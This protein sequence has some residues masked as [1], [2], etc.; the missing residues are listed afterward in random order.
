[1]YGCSPSH[2]VSFLSLLC[3]VR[4]ENELP[5]LALVDV[6]GGRPADSHEGGGA[7]APRKL[8]PL[9]HV[10][11]SLHSNRPGLQLLQASWHPHSGSHFAVLA[12]DGRLRLYS[13]AGVAEAEQ[14]FHLKLQ[15]SAGGGSGGG[16]AGEGSVRRLGSLG[17][18]GRAAASAAPLRRATAFVW[19]PPVG[20]GCFT[21][22]VLASD[23]GIYSLCPVAPFGVRVSARALGLLVGSSP[24]GTPRAWLQVRRACGWG[25]AHR[26]LACP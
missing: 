16:G 1:M 13:L 6:Y 22:L 7:G 19:G 14:T 3:R 25:W 4:Q 23:G 15:G 11:A 2:D 5:V 21:V 12:S 24:S 17:V 9:H 20:W 18:P 8:C 10:H 26:V